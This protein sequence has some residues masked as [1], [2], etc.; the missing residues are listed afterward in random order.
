MEQGRQNASRPFFWAL[1]NHFHQGSSD[2]LM[3][4]LPRS[5]AEN[6]LEEP[7]D[8]REIAPFLSITPEH[9]LLIH[10]SWLVDYLKKI[11]MP[12]KSALIAS[13]TEA[14]HEPLAQEFHLETESL[15]RLGEKVQRTLRET[16]WSQ[17]KPL[18][19][20]PLE[21][22]PESIFAPVLLWEPHYLIELIDTLGL[23]DLAVTLR[24]VVDKKRLQWVYSA[25]STQQQQ[26]LRQ[27]QKRR[28]QLKVPSIDL[29][30]WEGDRSWL[31]QQLHKR[32]LLRLG[33]ALYQQPED[34]LWYFSHR[35]DKARAQVILNYA[36]QPSPQA[37]HEVLVKQV[38]EQ[39][40]SI[41]AKKT[42]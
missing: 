20:L 42:L 18:H 7:S 6:L 2:A 25:L 36:R 1:I 24:Y 29:S 11:E 21:M 32:G 26:M 38:M 27:L 30:K 28:E 13:I 16:F 12:L 9:F 10:P 34:L 41:Q 4:M 5:L 37:V 3:K 40:Q 33:R 23:Y 22:L 31:I 14:L 39:I 19:I 17:I 35:F 8:Q 15:P